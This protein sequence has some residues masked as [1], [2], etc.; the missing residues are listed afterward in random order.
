MHGGGG[1]QTV[2]PPHKISF[3]AICF[4]G[5]RQ[6]L[7]TWGGHR[8]W[9]TAVYLSTCSDIVMFSKESMLISSSYLQ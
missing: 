2:F 3:I 4:Y 7:G 1:V 6:K 5:E 9:G 8:L